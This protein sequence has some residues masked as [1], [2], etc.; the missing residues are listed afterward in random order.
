[1]AYTDKPAFIGQFQ[2]KSILL[3]HE[4]GEGHLVPNGLSL[5]VW[6]NVYDKKLERHRDRHRIAG[7]LADLFLEEGPDGLMKLDGCFTCMVE[8]AEAFYIIRD[9]FG[10]GP[11]VY[12]TTSHF[13]S[14]LWHLTRLPGFTGQPDRKGL[15]TF[16][17]RGY[18]ATPL[19]AFQGVN[20]LGAGCGLVFK[21]GIVKTLDVVE[22]G[23]PADRSFS[24]AEWLDKYQQ[25]HAD[26]IRRRIE[27]S[28][29]VGILLSGGYDSGCNLLALRRLFSGNVHSFSIGFKGDGWSELPLAKC[30]SETFSTQHHTYEIDGSEIEYLSDM[31][32]L[33]GDPFV[34]GGLMVN[35][36]VMNMAAKY[37]QEVLLGGDGNDQLFG[38]TGREIALSLLIRR[39]GMYP[40]TVLLNRILN[41]DSFDRNTILYKV[42]F[43]TDK[44]LNLLEGDLFGLPDFKVRGLLNDPGWYTKEKGVK[45]DGRS[46]QSAFLQH[47]RLADLE[48]TI[49]Q[50]ILFKASQLANMFGQNLAFPYMDLEIKQLIDSMPLSFRWKGDGLLSIAQGKGESKSLL[51]RCYK[52]YL[53][54]MI[55][56]RKKQGGFA[57]MPLF[58]SDKQRFERV[59]SILLESSVCVDFLHRPGVEAFLHQY[60][61]ESSSASGWFWYRQNKAIQLFNLYALALWWNQ[62]VDNKNS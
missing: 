61:T 29:K 11:Q 12:Y 18:I 3:E 26:A 37:P 59:R 27:G 14:S 44:L 8:T 42:K 35:H 55:T 50:V 10:T 56:Q 9:R 49:N 43:H 16:L 57:P 17:T 20:K 23:F 54:E 41:R 7:M 2:Q 22:D 52:P 24:E 4:G 31:V 36:A 53:P 48:K 45:L 28:E 60:G 46:F 38:T 40:A 51:K 58:F 13:S 32:R 39:F 21:D 33:L 47:A 1:M 30:M 34:E 15:A 6:G 25:L 5:H 62:F 19:S